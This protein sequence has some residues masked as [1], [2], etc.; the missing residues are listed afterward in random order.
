MDRIPTKFGTATEVCRTYTRQSRPTNPSLVAVATHQQATPKHLT[1]EELRQQYGISLASRL[2][3][4]GDGKE[5]K[6]ADIDDDEDDWAPETIEW[7]DGTKTNLAVPVEV[8]PTPQDKSTASLTLGKDAEAEKAKTTLAKSPGSVGPNATVFKIGSSS[9]KKSGGLVMKGLAD[10]MDKPTLV[11]RPTASTPAK[12]PWAQ[13][14]PVEKVAPVAIHPVASNQPARFGQRDPHGFDAMPPPP[15]HAK[16]IAADDFSRQSRDSRNGASNQLFNAHSGQYEPVKEQRRTSIRKDHNN[17]RAHSVLQRPQPGDLNSPAEPSPA[18][19][20]QRTSA[21]QE[22]SHW[23]HRRAS[24]SISGDSG[25]ADRRQSL[26]QT[27][28]LSRFSEDPRHRRGSQLERVMASSGIQ[29]AN[30]SISPAESRRQSVVEGTQKGSRQ[31]SSNDMPSPRLAQASQEGVTATSTPSTPIYQDAAKQTA[32]IKK[33]MRENAAAALKRRKEEEAKEDAARRER[34]RL[35][36]IELDAKEAVNKA[37]ATPKVVPPPET[38]PAAEPKVEETATEPVPTPAPAVAQATEVDEQPSKKV[39]EP[40]PANVNGIKA[41]VDEF[42]AEVEAEAAVP[43]PRSFT[44]KEP[45]T[46]INSPKAPVNGS[47]DKRSPLSSHLPSKPSQ[48][49]SQHISQ[50]PSPENRP[51]VSKESVQQPWPSTGL[52]DP[53]PV[54]DW[55]TAGPGSGMTTHSSTT[56]N[57]WGPP[58][59]QRALGNGDFNASV[60]RPQPRNPHFQSPQLPSSSPQPIGPPRAQHSTQNQQHI[61]KSQDVRLQSSFDNSQHTNRQPPPSMATVT[62]TFQHQMPHQDAKYMADAFRST[63]PAFAQATTGSTLAGW[64]DFAANAG[65]EEAAQQEVMRRE[66]AVRDAEDARNGVAPAELNITSFTQTWRKV[67]TGK[68]ADGRHLGKSDETMANAPVSLP[69]AEDAPRVPSR[70]PNSTNGSNLP[71]A[72]PIRS[73][74]FPFGQLSPSPIPQVS[75][76]TAAGRLSSSPPPPDSEDHPAYA[77]FKEKALVNLPKPIPKVKLPPSLTKV[78]EAPVAAEVIEPESKPPPK[79]SSKKDWQAKFKVLFS[80]STAQDTK[81]SPEKKFAHVESSSKVPFELSTLENDAIITLPSVLTLPPMPSMFTTTIMPTVPSPSTPP[82]LPVQPVQ[83]AKTFQPARSNQPLQPK[84]STHNGPKT[85]PPKAEQ[86]IAK[87]VKPT[88]KAEVPVVETEPVAPTSKHVEDEQALYEED[89]EM[90]SKPTVRLPDCALNGGWNV[91]KPKTYR[92]RVQKLPTEIESQSAVDILDDDSNRFTPSTIVVHV[93]AGAPIKY[94]QRR[95]QHNT[96]HRYAN[97]PH[98]M[99]SQQGQ[100]SPNFRG[101]K[102]GYRGRSSRESSG[103]Y[104]TPNTPTAQKPMTPRMPIQTAYMQSPISR[105]NPPNVNWSRVAAHV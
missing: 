51:P 30:R 23:S 89:R 44:E 63:K 37:S 90:G 16:E 38:A 52:P 17:F 59:H 98:S 42:V 78:T 83:P 62:E 71:I 3:E 34:L 88:T 103:S 39:I 66:R 70:S 11:A 50:V 25:N 10:K 84:Q 76:Q 31:D 26:G 81:Q 18:F 68:D 2:Q 67:G 9:E 58:P 21:G 43:A 53:G 77:G 65:R 20:T 35:K 79:R 41:Q 4:D 73:K 54:T 56:A 69:I 45:A 80:R 97:Q 46:V 101:G 22:S 14:P 75:V 102:S 93:R 15:L 85:M 28:D 99:R 24:S 47:L 49:P 7:T 100:H 74:F 12:S 91:A 57:L 105:S 82:A 27:P 60:E 5:A 29:N 19:Q 48:L 33:V 92:P 6:W 40:R 86:S 32:D 8:P 95:G 96:H 64:A 87:A 36:M 61:S 55:S 104:Q 1:D 94:L 13:L 72:P